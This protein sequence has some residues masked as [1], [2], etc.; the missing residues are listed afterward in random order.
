MATS[1]HSSL[2][3]L[4]P[5]YTI[6]IFPLFKSKDFS[7]TCLLPFFRC[8]L[9]IT[10]L[11]YR[12]ILPWAIC[13]CFFVPCYSIVLCMHGNFHCY[14]LLIWAL[15]LLRWA[16]Y[17]HFCLDRLPEAIYCCLQ[18]YTVYD[19]LLIMYYMCLPVFLSLVLKGSYECILCYLLIYCL[20]LFVVV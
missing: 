1:I 6:P 14:N 2:S 12:F 5:F 11:F 8:T 13:C 16:S 4:L 9:H 15:S 3:C 10:F 20:R 7:F 18:T 17:R 19:V